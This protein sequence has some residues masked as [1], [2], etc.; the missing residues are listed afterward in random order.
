MKALAEI[1]D[2]FGIGT[3]AESKVGARARNAS[4]LLE[5][6]ALTG[7]IQIQTALG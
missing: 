4:P 7:L 5:A 2:L 1:R 3:E 6:L